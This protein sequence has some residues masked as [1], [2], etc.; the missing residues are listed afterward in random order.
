MMLMS[1]FQTKILLCIDSTFG[2]LKLFSPLI[3][4]SL[5]ITTKMGISIS[6]RGKLIF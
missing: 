4:Y 6:I 5:L 2:N 3:L 1:I